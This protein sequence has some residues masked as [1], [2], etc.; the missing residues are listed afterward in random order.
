M[1]ASGLLTLDF[2]RSSLPPR[3]AFSEASRPELGVFQSR[4]EKT[5]ENGAVHIPSG[6]LDRVVCL[7]SFDL[8]FHISSIHTM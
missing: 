5:A 2:H 3:N 7:A 4:L 8:L 1:E 6:E